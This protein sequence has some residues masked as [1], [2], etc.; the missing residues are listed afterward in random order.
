MIAFIN[1]YEIAAD[2]HRLDLAYEVVKR[3]LGLCVDSSHVTEDSGGGGGGDGD[4]GKCDDDSG[5]GGD[6]K[7]IS[8]HDD[9]IDKKS[10]TG[11]NSLT[12]PTNTVSIA[13]NSDQNAATKKTHDDDDFVLD[14]L[15]DDIVAQV[16]SKLSSMSHICLLSYVK[17][18]CSL[19]PYLYF[20]FLQLTVKN[21]SKR[22]SA[23]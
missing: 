8:I 5:I 6:T 3:Y 17:K 19:M 14:V 2:E 12:N 1:R 23:Q 11:S 4:D 7:K 10:L 13:N 9:Q 22:Q 18:I 16:R 21:Y 20:Y 15:N